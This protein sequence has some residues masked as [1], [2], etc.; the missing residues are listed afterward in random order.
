MKFLPLIKRKQVNFKQFFLSEYLSGEKK[1]LYMGDKDDDAIA[2]QILSGLWDY[3]HKTSVMRNLK[4]VTLLTVWL[5]PA[6]C[7]KAGSM[8]VMEHATN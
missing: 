8:S 1:G 3:S 7:I 2:L 6:Y 5:K 4:N